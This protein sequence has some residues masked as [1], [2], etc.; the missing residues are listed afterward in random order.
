MRNKKLLTAF[1]AASLAMPLAVSTTSPVMA[2]TT[3]STDTVVQVNGQVFM[4]ISSSF[5]AYRAIQ[6]GVE[7]S[8]VSGYSDRTFKPA[9]TVSEAEFLAMLVNAFEKN[10]SKGTSHWADPVY[11]I[12]KQKNYPLLA[13]NNQQRDSVKMTRTHVAE[14]VAGAFGYNYSGD[15]AIR[16]LLAKGLSAGKT[17]ATVSGYA[18]NDVLT[19]A[20]AIS[21]VKTLTEHGLTSLA[22]RPASPSKVSDDMSQVPSAPS[23]SSVL[24]NT[25]SGVVAVTQSNMVDQATIKRLGTAIGNTVLNLNPSGGKL[26]FPI[27][28]NLPPNWGVLVKKDGDVVAKFGGNFGGKVPAYYDYQYGPDTDVTIIYTYFGSFDE[29]VFDVSYFKGYKIFNGE[30]ISGK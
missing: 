6:W 18:E 12:A 7:N 23:S 24:R 19:R 22:T 25:V 4:D 17:S 28:N 8:V 10:L 26:R 29:P 2:A 14:I 5:W 16:Y 15:T 27:V 20:E 13:L 11:N 3:Q 30:A 9:K 21:F 1:L